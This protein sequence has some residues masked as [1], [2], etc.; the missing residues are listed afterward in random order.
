MTNAQITNT[1][2]AL[3]VAKMAAMSNEEIQQGWMLWSVRA[4][5]LATPAAGD[6]TVGMMTAY[7][8]EFFA[9]GLNVAFCATP[10]KTAKRAK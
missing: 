2:I 10:K 3:E 5:Q 1:A 8:N 7:T 9:R 6:F 4:G